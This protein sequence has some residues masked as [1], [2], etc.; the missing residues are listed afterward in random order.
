MIMTKTSQSGLS[1]MLWRKLGSPFSHKALVAL[2]GL[3]SM[4]IGCVN[5]GHFP[6]HFFVTSVKSSSSG[7]RC[8]GHLC[9][10]SQ[11]RLPVNSK[12][13][14]GH[15]SFATAPRVCM[16]SFMC[17]EVKSLPQVSH[18]F[19]GFSD[20]VASGVRIE[21][22]LVDLSVWRFRIWCGTTGTP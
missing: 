1:I 17:F 2:F 13:Q 21:R 10:C 14:Y 3:S 6:L 19:F 11:S 20:I 15:F 7:C 16:C 9:L 4:L 5:L 8:S 18:G 12:A 22:K